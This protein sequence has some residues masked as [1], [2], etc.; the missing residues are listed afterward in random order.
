[1]TGDVVGNVDKANFGAA[2]NQCGLGRGDVVIASAEVGGQRD[3]GSAAGHNRS[4]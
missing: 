1:M 3:D 2:A 4:G